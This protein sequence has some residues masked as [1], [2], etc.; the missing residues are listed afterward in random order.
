MTM[1]LELYFTFMIL[2]SHNCISVVLLAVLDN[3]KTPEHNDSQESLHNYEGQG[4]QYEAIPMR[5]I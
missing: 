1:L 2:S 3:V 4:H 5:T